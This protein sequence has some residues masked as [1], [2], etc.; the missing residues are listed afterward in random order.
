MATHTLEGYQK[1]PIEIKL[2]KR[3]GDQAYFD[4]FALS[5]LILVKDQHSSP[6]MS[7][8][9]IIPENERQEEN[10]VL[11]IRFTGGTHP[12]GLV[13]V[14]VAD[15]KSDSPRFYTDQNQN[16]DFSDD[17]PP[18]TFNDAVVNIDLKNQKKS[19]WHL[20]GD[21]ETLTSSDRPKQ[22]SLEKQRQ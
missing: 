6:R 16:G 19:K 5:A 20:S 18:L 22:G 17:E 14:L 13:L 10:G 12:S 9:L 8:K 11:E 7:I 3:P 1:Q 2:T 21:A 15:Y 4:D